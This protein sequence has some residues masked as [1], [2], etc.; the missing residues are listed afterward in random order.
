MRKPASFGKL[1]RT[2]AEGN[3]QRSF[4]WQGGL[5]AEVR[6]HHR[7]ISQDIV[8]MRMFWRPALRKKAYT[9]STIRQLP[10]KVRRAVD[11]NL[12]PLRIRCAQI[13]EYRDGL[14]LIAGVLADLQFPRMGRGLPVHVTRALKRNIRSHAIEIR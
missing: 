4:M 2:C 9:H 13:Q 8:C 5:Q 1:S 14:V 11:R 12:K 6:L 3:L 7:E 10:H